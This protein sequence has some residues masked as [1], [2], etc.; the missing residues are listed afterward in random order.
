MARFRRRHRLV[1]EQRQRNPRRRILKDDEVRRLIQGSPIRRAIVY[2]LMAKCF[3]RIHEVMK[4]SLDPQYIDLKAGYIDLPPDPDYGDKRRGPNR[5]IIDSEMRPLL[6]KYLAW[7]ATKVK[8]TEEGVAVTDKL[9]IT[10][11]GKAWC[12]NGFQ[13]NFRVMMHKDCVR[14]GIMTG[15]EKT[16][17]ERVNTSCFRAY[18][19]TRALDRGANSSQVQVL[20]GDKQAGVLGVYDN[21]RPRLDGLYRK[22]G[23]M[24]GSPLLIK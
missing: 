4:L 19:S 24:L 16:R 2:A 13:G 20:R 9:V 22:F 10:S 21:S 7:R 3:L 18:A 11:F 14:L 12:S 6:K 23:P 15:K 5:I 17:T 8:R 1:I